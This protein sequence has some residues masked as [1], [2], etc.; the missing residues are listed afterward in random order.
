MY[1]CCLK[2]YIHSEI[3]L[4]NPKT[5]EH[6]RH[7]TRLIEQKNKFNKPTFTSLER[8]NKYS[9]DITKKYNTDKPNKYLPP[10]LREGQANHQD[11]N[12]KWESE[13]DIV[14]TNCHLGTNAT[15][16][17]YVLVK[18]RKNQAHLT[19]I[20]ITKVKRKVRPPIHK[21]MRLFPSYPWLQ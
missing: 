20:Q 5:I 19:V 4:W 9:D 8:L 7:T 18:Q 17:N 11:S 10:H 3:K 2:G 14:E 15:I 13:C 12:K 21:S 16:K 1:I 6:A